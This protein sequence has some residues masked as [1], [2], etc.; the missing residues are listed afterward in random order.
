MTKGVYDLPQ[1]TGMTDGTGPLASDVGTLA[2]LIPLW[3]WLE[4]MTDKPEKKKL[5]LLI[6]QQ[7]NVVQG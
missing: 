6:C 4:D 3:N 7:F 1:I 2:T 5:W